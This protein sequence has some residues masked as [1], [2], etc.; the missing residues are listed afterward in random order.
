MPLIA[1][2]STGEPGVL[3][4]TYGSPVRYDSSIDPCALDDGSV[5]RAD[6]VRQDTSRRRSRQYPPRRPVGPR[7]PPDVRERRAAPRQRS[8]HRRGAWPIAASS[9]ALPP[10]TISAMTAPTSHSSMRPAVTI[11]IRPSTSAPTGRVEGHVTTSIASG[12]ATTTHMTISGRSVHQSSWPASQGRSSADRHECRDG[13]RPWS[14]RPATEIE[15][16]P[17]AAAARPAA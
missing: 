17:P 1:P 2:D 11:A 14:T 9:S 7:R 12:T 3:G 13:M 15:G 6:L 5:D 10:D 16:K 8:E 4:I